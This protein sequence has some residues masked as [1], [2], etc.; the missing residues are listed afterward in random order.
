M[1]LF[2]IRVEYRIVNGARAYFC[3]LDESFSLA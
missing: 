1:R 2:T 3:S